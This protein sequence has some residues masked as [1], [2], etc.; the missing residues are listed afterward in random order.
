MHPPQWLT[1]FLAGLSITN[2]FEVS[3]LMLQEPKKCG[4]VTIPN[5]P[6]WAALN[7]H[8]QILDITPSKP[9]EVGVNFTM[10]STTLRTHT[11][12]ESIQKQSHQLSL[13][14]VCLASLKVV[15]IYTVRTVHICIY[16]YRY[17]CVCARLRM[18]FHDHKIIVQNYSGHMFPCH[19]CA[20]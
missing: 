14:Y 10:G 2:T 17:M 7:W 16:T 13:I 18:C 8:L 19:R 5:L 6:C 20:S 11:Q 3:S 12:N 1:I 9:R 15:C 4:Q